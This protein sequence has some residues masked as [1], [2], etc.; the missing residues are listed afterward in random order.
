MALKGKRLLSAV[1][2]GGR[3]SL[4]KKEGF[5]RFTIREFLAPVNQ[6]ARICGMEYLPPFVVHGTHVLTEPEIAAHAAEYRALVTALRDNRVDFAAAVDLL[7]KLGLK[8]FYG[9]ASRHDKKSYISQARQRIEDLEQLLLSELDD[10][11]EHH[12]AGW[13]TESMREEFGRRKK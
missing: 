6:L 11:G 4:F 12:D 13:D 2:T 1:S 5:N 8:V 3:E 10:R 9:D 7:R